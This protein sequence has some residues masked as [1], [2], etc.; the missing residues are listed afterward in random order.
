MKFLF[1]L[2]I[3]NIFER[4]VLAVKDIIIVIRVFFKANIQEFLNFIPRGE[5]SNSE[6]LR[7]RM[8]NKYF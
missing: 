8:T 2:V 5:Y 7:F 6:V 3:E 1:Y 4:K